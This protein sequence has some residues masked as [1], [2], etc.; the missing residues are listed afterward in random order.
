[1]D[2]EPPE[3]AK[4][5]AHPGGAFHRAAAPLITFLR[6]RQMTESTD[7]TGE[8]DRSN[9]HDADSGARSP[10]RLQPPVTTNALTSLHDEAL[11]HY[12]TNTHV[13]CSSG[14][15]SNPMTAVAATNTG[16]LTFHL[17]STTRLRRATRAVSQSP[18]AILPSR[19]HAPRMV[20]IA[21]A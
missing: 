21:A 15:A 13:G 18:I 4:R 9:P 2:A 12:F 19:T 8:Q 6:P 17:N 11:L 3:Q 5:R 20:P 1:M 10:H 7:E 16:L 14:N